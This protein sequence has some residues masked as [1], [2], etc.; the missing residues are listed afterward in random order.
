MEE[1][2]MPRKPAILPDMN[3]L[4]IDH[5]KPKSRFNNALGNLPT[6]KNGPD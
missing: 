4:D 2:T 6:E 1:M 3:M 5:T